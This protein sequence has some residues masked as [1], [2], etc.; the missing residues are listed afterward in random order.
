MIDAIITMWPS[1]V[2]TKGHSVVMQWDRVF[3]NLSVPVLFAGDK[4][5]PGW[6]AATF[7]PCERNSSN[8]RLVTA[9][10]LDYDG[11]ETIDD[12]IALWGSYFGF[13]HTTRKH[14][15]EAPRFRVVLPFARRVS[16]AEYAR[17]WAYVFARAG[18]KLDPAPKDP[19]RFW[20]TPGTP[21]MAHFECRRLTGEYMEPDVILAD[22]ATHDGEPR[23]PVAPRSFE[24]ASNERRASAYLARMPEAISGSGGHQALWAAALAVVQGFGLDERT[25]FTILDREYNPRCQPRWNERDLSHK[26]RDAT[27]KSRLPTGYK[28]DEGRDWQPPQRYPTRATAPDERTERQEPVQD[29]GSIPPPEVGACTRYGVRSVGEMLNGVYRRATQ[30]KPERGSPTG[31]HAIDRVIGG[32]RR[33][34]VTVL[35]AST[36][37]GKSSFAVM[38]SDVGMRSDKRILLVSG[39]DGEDTYGQRLMAR[40]AGVNAMALRDLEITPKDLSRMAGVLGSAEGDPFFL[41]GIGKTAEYVGGAIK[42]IC[43]EVNPDLVIV[44]YLHAFTCSKRCQDRR[45]EITHIAR[46]FTDAIKNAG[47]AG[48][49]FSQLKR[50]EDG[51]RPTMHD[52]KE[53]GDVE[54]MA[55]HVLIGYSVVPKQTQERKRYI[56]IEKNKDGPVPGDAIEMPFDNVTA[57]F[58]EQGPPMDRPERQWEN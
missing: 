8:V 2:Q 3:D 55:E 25:A 15:P 39:E 5:H 13:M 53:S 49:I 37:W 22:L 31:V 27:N 50:L 17:I 40:R 42:S 7:D 20:F 14:N 51:Q 18:G 23:A 11:G 36:S 54:N 26:V 19:S 43:E 41:N 9:M 48:V 4:E 45:N 46:V 21:D 34:R 29:D 33:G 56:L 52:L 12:A 38:A 58:R 57:S 35:G 30:Q 6:S 47:A 16:P 24:P 10:V 1:L 28:L 44:D 32:F